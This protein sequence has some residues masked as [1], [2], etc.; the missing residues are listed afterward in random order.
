MQG[1]EEKCKNECKN[2]IKVEFYVEQ[3]QKQRYTHQSNVTF[4]QIT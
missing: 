4:C 3:L 2:Y 1:K